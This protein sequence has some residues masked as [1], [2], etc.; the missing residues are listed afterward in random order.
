MKRPSAR[1]LRKRA[2]R[3][4][5]KAPKLTRAT[6]TSVLELLVPHVPI[7]R[8][9]ANKKVFCT[10]CKSLYCQGFDGIDV[11]CKE[12]FYQVGCTK[13]STGSRPCIQCQRGNVMRVISLNYCLI[14]KT[15]VGCY[16]S[17]REP[18]K[19]RCD[20]C[21]SKCPVP[22]SK[23]RNGFCGKHYKKEEV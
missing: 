8:K 7:D 20:G 18:R 6:V 5:N 15:T 22:N 23:D 13:E 1:K 11:Y 16:D 19:L 17:E 9:N 3:K 12:C 4:R 2:E 21:T 10:S 14:C